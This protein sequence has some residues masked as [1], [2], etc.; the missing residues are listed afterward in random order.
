MKKI[1]KTG[2]NLPHGIKRMKKILKIGNNSLIYLQSAMWT[3]S[4]T[5][6][7]NIE[8]AHPTAEI[9]LRARRSAAG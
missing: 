7:Q 1:L 4:V 3:I 2:N 5:S 6:K 8:I 9:M